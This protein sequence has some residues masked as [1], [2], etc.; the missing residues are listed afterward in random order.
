LHSRQREPLSLD[1]G[2]RQERNRLEDLVVHALGLDEAGPRMRQAREHAVAGDE[3]ALF[4][5]GDPQELAVGALAGVE[6]VVAH[7]PKPPDQPPE[8]GVHDETG[9]CHG[10]S[11]QP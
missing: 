8:H 4:S 2:Q 6:R 9:R 3:E 5:L 11:L 1:R 7:G 10:A